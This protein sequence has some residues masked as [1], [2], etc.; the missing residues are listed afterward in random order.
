[1]TSGY[2]LTS[3]GRRGIFLI[4]C[5][6]VAGVREC[7]GKASACQCK[8]CWRQRSESSPRGGNG[9]TLQYSCLE[10][11]TDSGAWWAP[12]PWDCKQS[13]MTERL[14]MQILRRSYL[15]EVES[16]LLCLLEYFSVGRFMGAEPGSLNVV[17]SLISTGHMGSF[18]PQPEIEL[19][20][21]AL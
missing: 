7:S 16:S 19:T 12:C 10:N 2:D 6:T 8:R 4:L 21:L 18:V 17:S 1:M 9:N 20:S 13:D 15:L 14:S 11:S 3:S 5:L